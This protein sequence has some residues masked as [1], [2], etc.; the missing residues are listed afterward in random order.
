MPLKLPIL[1][2]LFGRATEFGAT[3]SDEMAERSELGLGWG[4]VAV[5]ARRYKIVTSLVILFA[6]LFLST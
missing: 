5:G 1:W 2:W 6:F 4:G 3:K